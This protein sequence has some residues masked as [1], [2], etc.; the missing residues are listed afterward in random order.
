MENLHIYTNVNQVI[1]TTYGNIFLWAWG[2]HMFDQH[3]KLM[4]IWTSFT[5]KLHRQ[6]GCHYVLRGRTSIGQI[7]RVSFII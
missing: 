2:G 1:W 3:F 7:N 5:Q 6:C 4:P